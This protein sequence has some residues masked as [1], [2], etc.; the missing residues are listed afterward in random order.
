VAQEGVQVQT[1]VLSMKNV[2]SVSN[3]Y[4]HLGYETSFQVLPKVL[5]L[6]MFMSKGVARMLEEDGDCND[7]E[8]EGPRG[9]EDNL[10]AN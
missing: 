1:S 8:E 4:Y 3:L 7:S 9:E 2:Q 5:N 10:D 6:D